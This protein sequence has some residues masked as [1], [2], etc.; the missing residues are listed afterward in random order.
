MSFEPGQIVSI[1]GLRSSEGSTLNT[2]RGIV[3][4]LVPDSEPARIELLVEGTTTVDT[5]N[6]TFSIKESNIRLVPRRPLPS[7]DDVHNQRGV[8]M[9]P[10]EEMFRTLTELL[11]RYTPNYS[12][13]ETML[14]GYANM[15]F[16]RLGKYNYM[17]FTCAEMEQVAGIAAIANAC[18]QGGVCACEAAVFALLEGDPMCLDVICILL[19]RTPFIGPEEEFEKQ[20]DEFD[21]VEEDELTPDQDSEPYCLFMKAGPILLL[22][23]MAKYNFGSALFSSIRHSQFYAQAVQRIVRIIA[24]EGQSNPTR[25]GRR[26]GEL[27][28]RI[29]PHFLGSDI[30]PVNAIKILKAQPVSASVSSALLKPMTPEQLVSSL[31][32][33][34]AVP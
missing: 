18:E 1:Y 29:L 5:P 9:V 20:E 13:P 28:R 21:S 24:R 19:F 6:K 31:P 16:Q 34:L 23:T 15:A 30:L 7:Q 25:D 33:L 11:V 3:L 10:D 17:A 26:L 32:Q 14:M 12:P 22:S 27:C 2:R 4:R 8:L